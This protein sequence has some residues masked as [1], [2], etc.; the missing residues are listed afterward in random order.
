MSAPLRIVVLGYIIRGPLGGLT[1]HHLQYAVG[2]LQQGH[3]VWFME[4]SDDYPACYNPDTG[5][6]DEDP[7]YGLGYAS[8]VFERV[9]LG[10][11]WAYFDAH[12]DQWHGP[13]APEAPALA[14]TADV[15]LNV[16]GVNPLRSWWERA[17][18]RVLIDT[19]PVFTQVRHLTDQRAKDA[20]AGHTDFFSFGENF[21]R[22]GC[23]IPDDGL[24][25]QA[26]RQ[27]VVPQLWPQVP[28]NPLGRYTTVMQ[29]ESYK[30]VTWGG[31]R[32]GMKADSFDPFADLPSKVPVGVEL[33]LAL[34][35]EQAPRAELGERGWHVSDPIAATR[36]PWIFQRYIESSRA[37]FSVAKHGYVASKS[38]WFSE[39]TTSYL[40]S[41]RPALTHD[42]GFSAFLP[43]G[44]GL[45]VFSDLDDA[46]SGIEEIE[47][48]YA[49]HCR[50][51]RRF[52]EEHFSA[53]LVLDS[54]LQRLR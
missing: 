40:V 27:P 20:A 11:R 7:T 37:E 19:D 42:T 14:A 34:G 53:H 15:V 30:H 38:G 52:V 35:S 39:R 50:G 18:A 25:W 24:P 17:D 43:D 41:G 32:F 8:R 36:D 49:F 12:T 33:E 4:D 1:W 16:S 51:A 31:Q 28:P 2:L 9:G 21:G 23:T 10:H 5:C 22:A 13:A 29:W 48:N 54:L 6:V 44:E 26:T 46:L 45:V 3:D 47:A